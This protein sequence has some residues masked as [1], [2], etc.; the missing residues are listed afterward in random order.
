MGKY[1]TSAISLLALGI[2]V[3]LC[4][5]GRSLIE[6]EWW[7]FLLVLSSLAFMVGLIVFAVRRILR[8]A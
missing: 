3:V 2:L 4:A 8:Q 1:K 7:T 6:W 5:V